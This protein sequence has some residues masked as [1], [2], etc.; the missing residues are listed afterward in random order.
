[1]I[2]VQTGH[3]TILEFQMFPDYRNIPAG[4]L[5]RFSQKMQPFGMITFP[6]HTVPRN[7]TH[8]PQL[9]LKHGVHFHVLALLF[10]SGFLFPPFLP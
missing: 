1:M 5:L 9:F 4:M 2:R 3:P 10:L 6:Y 7:P 8:E